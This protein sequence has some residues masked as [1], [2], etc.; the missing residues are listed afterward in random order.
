MLDQGRGCALLGELYANGEG[1]TRSAQLAQLFNARGC[2][3]GDGRS[4]GNVGVDHQLG[5]GADRSPARAARFYQRAC[6][7]GERRY[8]ALLQRFEQSN[9]VSDRP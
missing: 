8:C 5:F 4:C 9:D 3:L 2:A 7:A 1:V 6:E